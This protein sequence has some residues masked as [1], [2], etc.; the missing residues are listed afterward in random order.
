MQ[1]IHFKTT[2]L[3]RELLTIAVVLLGATVSSAQKLTVH[4]EGQPL[5][6]LLTDE[7]K[8]SVTTL[9]V[10][11]K[12]TEEDYALFGGKTLSKL[13]TLNLRNAD[14]DTIPVKAFQE[15]HRIEKIIL[16]EC[17][18]CV[19]D[20]AFLNYQLKKVELTGLFPKRGVNSFYGLLPIKVSEN[21]PYHKEVEGK[22]D[23]VYLLSSDGKTLYH[24]FNLTY[25]EYVPDG[26]ETVAER[27]FEQSYFGGIVF[28]ATLTRIESYAFNG[29]QSVLQEQELTFLS[30]TPPVLGEE[31]F[32]NC[33]I[34]KVCVPSAWGKDWQ[35]QDVQWSIFKDVAYHPTLVEKM[36]EETFSITVV[37]STLLCTSPTAAKL[38]VYTLD[39]VKV[40][41][42]IF[43]NGEAKVQVSKTHAAYLYIVTYSDGHRESGKV[44][45]K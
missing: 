30:D 16:P 15:T 37:S 1:T 39:A 35:E 25:G 8:E 4:V 23:A 14:I 40:G 21:N 41:E 31:V 11:G 28:P 17:L 12:L 13:T 9:T 34:D 33:Y 10:T 3:K 18:V 20:S 43:A 6:S 32:Q 26:V 5:E 29:C 38:E 19:E 24:T 2:T 7:Q 45:V 22:D 44:M 36:K 27:A 42:A